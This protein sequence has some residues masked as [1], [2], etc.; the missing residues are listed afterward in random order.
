MFILDW[1]GW[2]TGNF[3]MTAVYLL[4]SCCIIMVAASGAFPEP[5]KEEA[6][7]LV[8]QNWREPLRGKTLG[9]GLANDRILSGLVLVTFL[10]L[11]YL[12]R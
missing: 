12:F 6:R 5:L 11:Y 4:V 7:S 8:W 10:I 2:Y 9:H 1:N 3:M